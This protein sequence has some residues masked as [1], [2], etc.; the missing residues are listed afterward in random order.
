VAQDSLNVT[1]SVL[2]YGRS[3]GMKDRNVL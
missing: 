3:T 2:G 1:A